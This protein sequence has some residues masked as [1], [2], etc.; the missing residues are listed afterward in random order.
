MAVLRTQLTALHRPHLRVLPVL[1]DHHRAPPKTGGYEM[2]LEIP[3]PESGP[4][5]RWG[6]PW[7]ASSVC[8]S[9]H[10]HAVEKSLA[11]RSAEGWAPAVTPRQDKK[12]FAPAGS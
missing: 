3:S 11:A 7:R 4:H 1:A 12:G 6:W 2:R 9:S 10:G 5:A 8:L